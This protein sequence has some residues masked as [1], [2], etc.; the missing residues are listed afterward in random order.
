[1][2]KCS[3]GLRLLVVCAAVFQTLTGSAFGDPFALTPAGV[4]DGF[5]VSNFLTISGPFVGPFNDSGVAILPNGDALIN[6]ENF[7]YVFRN[8]DGQTISSALFSYMNGTGYESGIAGAGGQVYGAG[9]TS[10]YGGSPNQ[11][12]QFNTQGLIDHGL[13][14]VTVGAPGALAANP[15]NGHLIASTAAGLV[16]VDPLANGSLGSFRIITDDVPYHGAAAF[17]GLAVS[18]DGRTVYGI[19]YNQVLAYDIAS[20]ALLLNNY[21]SGVGTE[22]EGLAVITSTNSLNGDLVINSFGSSN[23]VRP[24]HQVYLYDPRTGDLSAIASTS[25]TL[26][27]DASPDSSNGTLF[28][29]HGD[30]IDRL[31]CGPDCSFDGRLPGS[32]AV[33]EPGTL[34]LLSTG[35]ALMGALAWRRAA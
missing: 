15:V 31:S 8:V 2:L 9:N 23:P 12:V 14:D 34:W 10:L 21:I 4:S 28:L 13:S 3:G 27:G 20:G 1:M 5:T 26:F 29:G 18:A 24:P 33:P 17:S 19:L 22:L 11:F 16:D 32:S 35:V 25:D 6:S 30:S 7:T